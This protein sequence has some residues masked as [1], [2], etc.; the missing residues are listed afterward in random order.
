MYVI[1]KKKPMDLPSLPL[2]S[3]NTRSNSCLHRG[4][5]V[6]KTIKRFV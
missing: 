4:V 1:C 6:G 2:C 5:F 3:I